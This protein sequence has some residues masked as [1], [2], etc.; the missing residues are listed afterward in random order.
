MSLIIWYAKTGLFDD[1][2]VMYVTC[3]DTISHYCLLI[4]VKTQKSECEMKC[5]I[6]KCK[7]WKEE[8]LTLLVVQIV[9]QF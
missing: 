2:S 8:C 9:S 1:L 7:V 3:I 6:M 4:D 5:P